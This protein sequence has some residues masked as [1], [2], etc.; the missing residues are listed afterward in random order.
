MRNS[1]LR[2]SPGG[3]KWDVRREASGISSDDSSIWPS[4]AAWSGSGGEVRLAVGF[5]DIPRLGL[6]APCSAGGWRR[7]PGKTAM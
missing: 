2:A 4:L 1:L 7:R 3:V 5:P 6:E